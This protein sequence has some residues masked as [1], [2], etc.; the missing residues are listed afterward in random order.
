[1]KECNCFGAGGISSCGEL[2]LLPKVIKIR[3]VTLVSKVDIPMILRNKAWTPQRIILLSYLVIISLGTVL[4]KLPI[5]VNRDISLLDA[6][7]T[8]TSATTVT[9]L[10]AIDIEKDLTFFGQLV[11][12]FLI[13][14][15]GLGYLTMTTYLLVLFRRK[16]GL[17]ERMLLSES[18]NYPSIYGLIRFAKKV[19]PIVLTVEILG[20][21]LLILSMYSARQSIP[22]IIFYAIFHSVSAFNNA[23]FSLFSDNLV[24]FRSDIVVNLTICFLIITGGLGFFVIY[25]LLS[26]AKGEIK[27]VSTHTKLVLISSVF[28]ILIGF[29]VMLLD[30]YR[31][32]DLSVKE[33]ILASLFHSVSARTAGFNTIDLARLSEST[34]FLIMNLMFVGASPGGT[35]GGIKTITMTVIVIAVFSFI[36]GSREVVIFDRS[37]SQQVAYKS[38]VIISLSFVYITLVSLI[39]SEMEGRH[40]LHIL[41]EVVSAFATV[42][43]SI[44]N[45]QGLSLSADFS[46]IGKLIIVL[47]MIVGRIGILTFMLA[48]SGREK[49]T[50]L[51][52]PEARILL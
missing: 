25:E 21:V 16:V 7:F 30:V 51:K 34:L 27:R 22:E 49:I 47:T 35:G 45:H 12:L 23:G 6:L 20:A 19:I 10:V 43:L 48:I 46:P 50:N 39:L 33:K 4:L 42:G 41:F 38:M 9:G 17:K 15:G 40:M 29:L 32:N 1:M 37:I 24:R 2:K 13:Q 11:I 5:S 52:H 44:G 36:R 26:I 8:S 14:V 28:L 18:L 3:E 31:F